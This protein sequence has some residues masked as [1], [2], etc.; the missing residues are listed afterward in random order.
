MEP[1]RLRCPGFL[2]V[3]RTCLL[4]DVSDGAQKIT[5]PGFFRCPSDIPINRRLLW[6]PITQTPE[7]F[8]QLVLKKRFRCEKKVCSG[9]ISISNHFQKAI[10]L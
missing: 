10:K 3:L 5:L 8:S 7:V 9:T 4:I 2:D 6:S 1:K